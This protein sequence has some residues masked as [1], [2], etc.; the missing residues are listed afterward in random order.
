MLK[1]TRRAFTLLELI[2]VIIILGILAALAIPTFLK[3]IQKSKYATVAQTAASLDNDAVALAA[4]N[5]QSAAATPPTGSAAAGAVAG[6]PT[7]NGYVNEALAELGSNAS[8]VA[9]TWTAANGTVANDYVVHQVNHTTSV[10]L[11]LS[12][13]ENQ[14]GTIKDITPG[15]TC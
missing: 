2:V 8:G 1:R 7:T 3:V 6:G 4:F 12:A 10:C 14:A 15:T 13:Q 5:Q 11:T 9:T